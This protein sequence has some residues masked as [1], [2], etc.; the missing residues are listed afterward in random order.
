MKAAFTAAAAAFVLAAAPPVVPSRPAQGVQPAPRAPQAVQI[1]TRVTAKTL[2]SLCASDNG[3]CLAYV[4]GTADAYS[5]ALVA[6]GR[7]QVFCFPAG[8]TNQ[9]ISQSAVQYLRARPQEGEN[10][11]ALLLMSAFTAIYP[12]PR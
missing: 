9:Q 1:P 7:P 5:T 6:S 11:A 8:T 10:N 2:I 12:C 4:I 3:T